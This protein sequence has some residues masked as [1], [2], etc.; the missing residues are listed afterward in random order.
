MLGVE[1]AI[2]RGSL[3]GKAV[4][5]SLL[6]INGLRQRVARLRR[7][8]GGRLAWPAHAKLARRLERSANA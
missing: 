8:R 7:R 5:Q 3:D 2:E 4:A 6:R 1:R